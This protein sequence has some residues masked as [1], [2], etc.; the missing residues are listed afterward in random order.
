MDLVADIGGTSARLALVDDARQSRAVMTYRCADFSTAEA[1]LQAYLSEV[2]VQPTRAAIAVAGPV[3]DGHVNMTNLGWRISADELQ[4]L[5][6]VTRLALVND[7]AA[8]AQAT[9]TF[10][11]E[12][13]YP[14]GSGTAVVQANRVI[15]G[16]GTGLGVSGLICSG[17][18]WTT[19]VG[20][21]GHVS[22]VARTA[23]EYELIATTQSEYGHCSAERLLS[24]SGLAG[25]YRFFS[26]TMTS[27]TVTPE[28]V[29]EQAMAGDADALHA[30]S[31]FAS[32]LGS[33]AA[34]L[35]L[36]FGARGG[37]YLTGGILPGLG[38]LLADTGF[39][40]RFEDKGRMSAY[41]A[42]I[43]VYI[44]TAQN[45]GL[46]GLIAGLDSQDFFQD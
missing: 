14:L 35:A 42:A 9:L 1:V 15:M 44:V 2:G 27:S 8:Q 10:T 12:E 43:P 24:G 30:F 4:A 37:V 20:E 13:L 45:P 41:L 32:L 46:R 31:V 6:G 17:T 3:I 25:I 38:S 34:D 28:Q 11:S 26:G 33:V 23:E 36:T 7:F 40:S 18:G 22:L 39:R 19:V 21:G 16:P 29:S 5:L